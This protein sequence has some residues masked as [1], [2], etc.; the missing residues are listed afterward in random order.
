MAIEPISPRWKRGREL[1]VVAMHG[2]Q[3]RPVSIESAHRDEVCHWHLVQWDE[4][5]AALENARGRTSPGCGDGQGA[6]DG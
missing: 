3:W 6:E 1:A 2:R 4:I 5:Q